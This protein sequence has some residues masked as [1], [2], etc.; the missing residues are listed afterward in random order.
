MWSTSFRDVKGEC[1]RRR[2]GVKG[3]CGRRRLGVKGVNVD[4][5]RLFIIYQ[6]INIAVKRFSAILGIPASKPLLIRPLSDLMKN[7]VGTIISLGIDS[8]NVEVAKLMSV[9]IQFISIAN[10]CKLI[11]L[12]TG[13]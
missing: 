12:L 5:V 9:L 11:D 10:G 7:M 2:L 3:E 4:D 8:N 1:G 6:I 13:L